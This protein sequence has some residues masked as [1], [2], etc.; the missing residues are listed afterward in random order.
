MGIQNRD[1]GLN[2]QV[3]N[4]YYSGVALGTSTIAIPAVG[5][6]MIFA[7]ISVPY[8][9]QVLKITS[10]AFGLSGSPILGVQIQRFIGASGL[11]TIPVNG[12][13]LLTITAFS[14]SG[15]QTHSLPAVGNSLVQLLSGDSIQLVSSAS[16]TAASY[17]VNIVTQCLQD[18]KTQY[19][20][21]S[22]N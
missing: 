10:S 8:T 21:F 11:T 17:Q 20:L 6:S 15:I 14:T 3:D 1:K 2:E 7:C 13:S 12:S 5:I 9:G 22:G 16:N 4:W 19:G 18:F